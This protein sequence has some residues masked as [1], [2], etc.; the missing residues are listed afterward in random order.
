MGTCAVRA[1]AAGTV[2]QEEGWSGMPGMG[3][4][5]GP[6]PQPLCPWGAKVSGRATQQG[7]RAAGSKPPGQT[8]QTHIRRAQSKQG[9]QAH[10]GA[11]TATAVSLAAAAG[12]A[13]GVV[14]WTRLGWGAQGPLAAAIATPPG[15][16]WWRAQ[17]GRC[18]GAVRAAMLLWGTR[19]GRRRAG[20]AS[21]RTG[22]R[23]R[24]T[25]CSHTCP[26][27]RGGCVA[28]AC[29]EVVGHALA[30]L[31]GCATTRMSAHT[32]TRTR[33]PLATHRPPLP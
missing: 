6:L 22:A 24:A 27:R 5:K 12:P 4:S 9:L 28:C 32:H 14:V 26:L 10:A 31:C 11:G 7:P 30:N 33:A 25:K 29:E 19:A 15:A 21:V 13:V 23:A 8:A 16:T 17:A 1:A 20:C 18:M 2:W 3:A